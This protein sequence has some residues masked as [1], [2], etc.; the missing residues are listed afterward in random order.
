[1]ETRILIDTYGLHVSINVEGPINGS[2]GG[3]SLNTQNAYTYAD[4][5]GDFKIDASANSIYLEADKLRM[6]YD[7]LHEYYT[8]RD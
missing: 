4:K 6:L 3:L 8:R 1:M 7:G 2:V 5:N